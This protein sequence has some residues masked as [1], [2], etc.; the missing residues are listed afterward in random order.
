MD[1]ELTFKAIS[2]G[3]VVLIW[4]TAVALLWISM[5]K[6]WRLGQPLRGVFGLIVAALCLCAFIVLVAAY[7]QKTR[8]LRKISHRIEAAT[9]ATFDAKKNPASEF[10]VRDPTK[11]MNKEKGA[12]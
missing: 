8:S 10:E 3:L 6:E 7:V 11:F 5:T 1:S 4:L 12:G 2:C 9:F